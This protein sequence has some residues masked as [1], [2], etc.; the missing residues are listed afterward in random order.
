MKTDL[1]KTMPQID[2]MILGRYNETLWMGLS[3][4]IIDAVSVLFG[5]KPFASSSNNYLKG[6][7]VGISYSFTTNKLGLYKSGKSSGDVEVMLRYSF[8]IF[9]QEVFSGYGSS[10]NIYKNQ[11]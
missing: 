10:R 5:A 11:Y 8:D 4:R 6:L 3:Y 7:D 2:L 9:K 1:T